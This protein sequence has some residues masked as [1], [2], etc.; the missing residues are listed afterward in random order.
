MLIHRS[1][2]R[3]NRA[4][5]AGRRPTGLDTELL[6]RGFLG[7]A[8]FGERGHCTMARIPDNCR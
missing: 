4:N 7:V 6:K 8:A 3:R 1:E 2:C 5:I